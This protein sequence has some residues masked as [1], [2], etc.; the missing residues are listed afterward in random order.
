M[1]SLLPRTP[2]ARVD[3]NDSQTHHIYTFRKI[4]L[5]LRLWVY[6]LWVHCKRSPATDQNKYGKRSSSICIHIYA[7]RLQN[8]GTFT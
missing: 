2:H 1:F 8:I 5:A 7:G 6:R 4:D 3:F